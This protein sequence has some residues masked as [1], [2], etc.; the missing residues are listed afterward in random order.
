MK[1]RV[2]RRWQEDMLREFVVEADE[3]ELEG[4]AMGIRVAAS[5][6]ALRIDRHSPQPLLR[7]ML[8]RW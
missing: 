8:G 2:V 6:L 7:R 1:I 3:E 4:F 5:L